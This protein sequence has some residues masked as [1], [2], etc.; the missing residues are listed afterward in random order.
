[1][2]QMSV[3]HVT[4][5]SELGRSGTSGTDGQ[6]HLLRSSRCTPEKC[7]LLRGSKKMTV[8]QVPDLRLSPTCAHRDKAANAE[9]VALVALM[10]VTR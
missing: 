10:A 2:V 4:R 5:I 9:E 7:H 1:M 3:T 6:C 8:P